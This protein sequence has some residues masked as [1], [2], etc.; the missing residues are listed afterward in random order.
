MSDETVRTEMR[1]RREDGDRIEDYTWV[2]DADWLVDGDPT[3]YIVEEWRCVLVERRVEVHGQCGLCVACEGEG[4]TDD[5]PAEVCAS[6][7]GD[8]GG[9]MTPYVVHDTHPPE[10]SR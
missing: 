4:R 9:P 7:D 6:C 2:D 5:I 10:D 1:Y 3:R 8:G